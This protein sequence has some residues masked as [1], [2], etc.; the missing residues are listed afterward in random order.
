[1]LAS[2]LV[3]ISFLLYCMCLLKY[4]YVLKMQI[5]TVM[6]K[7]HPSCSVLAVSTLANLFKT[8]PV[9]IKNTGTL[10]SRIR[11]WPTLTQRSNQPLLTLTG[12]VQAP[13]RQSVGH[14][15]TSSGQQPVPL[16]WPRRA[17]QTTGGS[18]IVFI[19]TKKIL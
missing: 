18:V 5:K 2:G 3:Q 10:M 1:M 8:P 4:I 15:C 9:Q 14:S 13:V 19:S 17:G 6:L 7:M 12:L 11:P 16:C